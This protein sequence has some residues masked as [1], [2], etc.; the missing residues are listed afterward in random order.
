[1]ALS[2]QAQRQEAILDYQEIAWFEADEN[3]NVT[4][5]SRSWSEITGLSP[6]EAYGN[7]WTRA[8]HR[9]DRVSIVEQ[10][11]ATVRMNMLFEADFRVL[12]GG[13]G[14]NSMSRVYARANPLKN[15]NN[16]I[17]ISGFLRTMDEG[18]DWRYAIRR[19]EEQ[20]HKFQKGIEQR[21]VEIMNLLQEEVTA[22]KN[23]DGQKRPS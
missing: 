1:V 15:K 14:D 21:Q 4:K 8:I 17:G 6:E 20:W 13:Y 9:D 12:K 16:L 3:G 7:G 22:R 18:S 2:A 11:N 19:Q 5:V 23:I 10:W